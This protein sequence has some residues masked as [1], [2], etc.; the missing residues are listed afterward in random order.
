MVKIGVF[1]ENCTYDPEYMAFPQSKR[2]PIIGGALLCEQPVLKITH[3]IRLVENER[4]G[5]NLLT[6]TCNPGPCGKG[7]MDLQGTI[8][9]AK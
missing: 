5:K 1:C 4:A 2:E 7:C 6:A 3:T 9:Q 8:L